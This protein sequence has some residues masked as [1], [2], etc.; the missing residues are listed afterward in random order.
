MLINAILN[1]CLFWFILDF[2][3]RIFILTVCKVLL[4]KVYHF[5]TSL[6]S[7]ASY[8]KITFF[9]LFSVIFFCVGFLISCLSTSLSM[10]STASILLILLWIYSTQLM[11][12]CP[13]EINAILHTYL[14]HWWFLH[15][16][17]PH[18]SCS[19]CSSKTL[20]SSS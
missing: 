6:N 2:Y 15:L 13:L 5:R 16:H 9:L 12:R 4:L 18:S 1:Y 10:L 3:C 8:K 14:N 7:A 19:S 17:N 20:Y 11:A